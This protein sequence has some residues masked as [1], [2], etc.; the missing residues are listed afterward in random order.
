MATLHGLRLTAAASLVQRWRRGGSEGD[1]CVRELVGGQREQQLLEE[2]ESEGRLLALRDRLPL[3]SL[4]EVLQW[5]KSRRRPRP[6]SDASFAD[7]ALRRPQ[8]EGEKDCSWRQLR[9]R[10]LRDPRPHRFSDRKPN[11]FLTCICMHKHSMSL[12]LRGLYY[13]SKIHTY[14]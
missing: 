13:S 14:D 2:L 9:F 4:G 7:T 11:S 12:A 5:Q 10:W 1:V 3:G 6:A 8:D